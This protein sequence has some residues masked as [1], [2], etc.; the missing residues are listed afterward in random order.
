MSSSC[1]KTDSLGP[2]EQSPDTGGGRRVYEA[3]VPGRHPPKCRGCFVKW[4]GHIQV[5]L[6]ERYSQG[7]NWGATELLSRG[8]NK[9]FNL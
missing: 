2:D 7:G 4:P 9:L 8:L 6:V 5:R 3:K 1:Y